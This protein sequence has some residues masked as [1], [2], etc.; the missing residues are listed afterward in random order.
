MVSSLMALLEQRYADSLNQEAREFIQ[1]AVDGATRM[2]NLLDGLLDYS[3]VRSRDL[4]FEELNLDKPVADA[5]ANLAELIRESGAE[6]SVAALPEIHGDRA[7]LMQL[8]Q[9][10]I[11]NGIKF[12]AVQHQPKII[13]DAH[14]D[15]QGWLVE[16][17][18]NGIGIEPAHYE[19][20][21]QIF[22]RLH[23]RETYPGTGVGLA[24]CKQ[25]MERHG[26][27]IEVESV[28]GQGTT[29]KLFF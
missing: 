4:V 29:F 10:L 5:V 18:D 21:F 28:P 1:F 26:G 7:Q 13:I 3:R 22:S 11:A 23:P 8:F 25:I 2:R 20:I 17:S 12:C 19:R 27:R 6:I 15:E 24:V 16:V 9:N 14:R